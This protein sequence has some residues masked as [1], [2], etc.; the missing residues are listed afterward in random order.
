MRKFKRV[1]IG[2]A[3]L[4]VAVAAAFMA[5]APRGS[6]TPALL[7]A[8]P[9]NEAPG[10][11]QPASNGG[12]AG[13]ATDSQG[14]GG[15]VAAMR[16]T[17]GAA[18]AAPQ[19][20]AAPG[21]GAA[22]LP[23]LADRKIIKNATISLQVKDVSASLDEL[24]GLAKGLNGYVSNLQTRYSGDELYVQATITV[25][26]AEFESTMIKLRGMAARVVSE[27]ISSQ[28]VTEEYV[29]LDAQ[30]R[31][32]QASEAQLLALMGKAVKVDEILA[33]QRELNNVR[34]QMERV[35]GRM[36]FIQKKSDMATINVSLAPV[37]APSILPTADPRPV[38]TFKAALATLGALLVNL[39]DLAIWLVVFGAPLLLL[40]WVARAG[41]VH[42]RRATT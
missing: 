24:T 20:A 26:A 1:L 10:P 28:D 2:G 23:S 42:V 3:I 8:L 14:E 27:N 13:R 18:P 12:V 16:A 17:S 37:S 39:G 36:N 19:A 34:T 21:S 7:P 41:W 15:G 33:V 40:A 4:L 29:D 30:L 32:L 5:F 38:R 25:P 31:S 9:S 22:S 6:R 35:K 11:A